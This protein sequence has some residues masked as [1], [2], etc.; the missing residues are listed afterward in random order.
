MAPLKTGARVE[1]LVISEYFTDCSSFLHSCT[2]VLL[3]L[4]ENWGIFVL[5]IILCDQCLGSWRCGPVIPLHSFTSSAKT[6]R[7]LTRSVITLK[8][9]VQ[10]S[11]ASLQ[12]YW[13]ALDLVSI[14][15]CRALGALFS[16]P[17]YVLKTGGLQL[18][19][20]YF[21]SWEQGAAQFPTSLHL[22][23]S[24]QVSVSHVPS[25]AGAGAVNPAWLPWGQLCAMETSM[26]A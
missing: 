16:Q 7:I 3:P 6:N 20:M 8:T 26:F 23:L 10:N 22:P 21:L 13:T 2:H 14:T 12:C 25:P 17:F 24:S 19:P 9:V 4:F 15:V 5:K 11:W 1:K 18:L